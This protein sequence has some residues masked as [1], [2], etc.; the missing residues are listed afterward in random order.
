MRSTHLDQSV[1][2]VRDHEF[3]KAV[4]LSAFAV[5]L[6]QKVS[7]TTESLLVSRDFDSS[8]TSSKGCACLEGQQDR[9]IGRGKRAIGHSFRHR[10]EGLDRAKR[11]A[12]GYNWTVGLP[13]PAI[14]LDVSA[15]L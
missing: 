14:D 5:H 3:R 6:S 10:V 1:V 7:S 8:S 4:L 11:V 9:Q 2:K 13:V 15:G 12:V